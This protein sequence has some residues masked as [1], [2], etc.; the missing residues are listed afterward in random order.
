MK[1]VALLIALMLLVSAFTFAVDFSASTNLAG[2]LWGTD[3]FV[4]NSPG[5]KDADLLTVDVSDEVWGSH[6]R[7]CTD[8]VEGP[9]SLRKL[10]I[11]VKPIDML[12]ITVGS[13]GSGLYTEQLNWYQVS[14]GA[15]ATAMDW[16]SDTATAG[17]GVNLE[18][19]PMSDL[20]ILAGISPGLATNF[21]AKDV[22]D[23]LV[24]GG[25]TNFGLAAKYTI[26]DFGSV[27]V[28]YRNNGGT[29]A[30]DG[31]VAWNEMNFRLGFDVTSVEGLY[32]FLQG[33]FTVDAGDESISG[34][35]I[36]EFVSYTAG[37]FNVK[38]TF[39]VTIRVTGD[40]GDDNYMT[41]DVKA[42]Y[43][44]MENV[45][46][47]VRLEQQGAAI[48]LNDIKF[49]PS[50]K[51]GADYSIGSVNFMTALQIN[52]PDSDVAGAEVTWSIP[53]EMRA[54]W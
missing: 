45:T 21:M 49:M 6:F 13:I 28:A 16:S 15:I 50:I 17:N 52:V 20:W 41:Y 4:L 54:S 8:N 32:A 43:K 22:D 39:P 42:G 9:V 23:K 1:K 33:I 29:T 19:T 24:V 11:W 2:N 7:L 38:A 46:P 10:N 47:F 35:V 36:D 25:D 48:L 53:F 30:A 44:V 27:G 5:Q 26:A 51:L 37:D 3:G 14:N 31:T 12:K 40:A 18:L 34:I